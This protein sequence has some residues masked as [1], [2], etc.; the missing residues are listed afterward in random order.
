MLENGK[1]GR[2][3]EGCEGVAWLAVLRTEHVRMRTSTSMNLQQQ[4][5]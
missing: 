5:L 2:T 1:Y 4:I 3:S